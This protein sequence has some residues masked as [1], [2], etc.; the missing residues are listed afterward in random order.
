MKR[1]SLFFLALAVL[2]APAVAFAQTLPPPVE[3][4]AVLNPVSAVIAILALVAGFVFQAKNS[5]SIF[6]I[7]TVPSAWLPYLGL[8]GGF[9]ANFVASLSS[10]TTVNGTAWFNATLAGFLSLT[11]SAVGVTIH[12]HVV[13][14]GKQKAPLDPVTKAANAVSAVLLL[15]ALGSTQSACL[16]SAPIVPVTPANTAQVSSCENTATLH[17]GFVIGDVVVGGAGAGLGAAA[18]AV[19]DTN[20]KTG[21][22]VGA[23]GA[24]AIAVALTALAEVTASNFVN[25]Q[26]AT[27]VGPLPTTILVKPAAGAVQ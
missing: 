14:G 22:G 25:S 20:A 2:S 7:A 26:C 12:Q 23:A 21:L 9:L 27:V 10:A 17:D 3:P 15:L 18:A 13:G 16:S 1:T 11:G 6:G 24:G 4:V 19:S 5:G 8:V